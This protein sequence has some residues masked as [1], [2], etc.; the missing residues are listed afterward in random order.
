MD[1]PESNLSGIP[2]IAIPV[3]RDY[4][5]F[6]LLQGDPSPGDK[7]AFKVHVLDSTSVWITLF[8]FWKKK[9]FIKTCSIYHVYCAIHFMRG[10]KSYKQTLLSSNLELVEMFFQPFKQFKTCLKKKMFV[11]FNVRLKLW[12]TYFCFES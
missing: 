7:I 9:K 3:R 8:V 4:Q 1:I 6:P 12:H 11:P 2:N 5:K 10:N